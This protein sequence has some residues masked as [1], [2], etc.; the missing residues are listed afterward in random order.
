[1]KILQK[2][3]KKIWNNSRKAKFDSLNWKFTRTKLR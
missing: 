1:M 2:E 3:K